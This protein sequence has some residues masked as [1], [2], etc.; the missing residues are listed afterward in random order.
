MWKKEVVVW[1]QV[2]S[3]RLSGG[4][5]E[6]HENFGPISAPRIESGTFRIRSRSANGSAATF[7]M[8]KVN[9]WFTDTATLPS[10]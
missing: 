1:F 7:G 5:E 8:N 9:A 2:L 4:I 3:R 6:N 10:C